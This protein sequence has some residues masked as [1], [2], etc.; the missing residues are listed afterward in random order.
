MIKFHTFETN[1]EIQY[2]YIW[3]TYLNSDPCSD[4]YA[5]D[6]QKMEGMNCACRMWFA[7]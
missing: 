1:L 5:N 3:K 7:Q 4:P 6:L 2:G